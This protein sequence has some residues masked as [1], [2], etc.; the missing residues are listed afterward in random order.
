MTTNKP[1]RT[2]WKV[3]IVEDHLL[4]RRRTAQLLNSQQGLKVVHACETMPEFMTWLST[5]EPAQRPHLLVLDLM[6]EREPSVD[7]RT[8]KALVDAGLRILVLSALASPPLVKEVIRAGVGGVVGKRDDEADI[9]AAVW[10]VLQRGEWFTTEVAGVI[11]G[12][13]NR[14]VLSVQEERALVLYASGLTLS[15]VAESIGVKPDTAKQYLDRVKAK[16]A[17]VGRPVRTKLDLGKVAWA[18]GY[19]DPSQPIASD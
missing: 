18:D 11:A 1:V 6:V 8:V 17:A 3:A 19:V 7:P 2:T 13:P 9:V 4:Q 10:A 15:A 14:P 16:Y 12:D 5:S